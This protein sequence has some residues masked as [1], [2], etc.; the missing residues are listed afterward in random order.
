MISIRRGHTLSQDQKNSESTKKKR[1]P[2]N[3]LNQLRRERERRGWSQETLAELL[4]TSQV[5]VSRWEQG[6]SLPGPYYRR[7]L[8]ERFG[9]SLQDLG[10]IAEETTKT[11]EESSKNN[12]KT[13]VM[14]E[15]PPSFT[16]FIGR[17]Q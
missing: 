2:R 6:N 8:A 11:T 12:L 10:L 3:S 9:K 15:M 1:S 7:A 17:E 16:S 13:K 14:W 4:G 5:N